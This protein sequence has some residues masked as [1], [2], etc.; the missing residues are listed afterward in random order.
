VTIQP[1]AAEDPGAGLWLSARIAVLRGLDRIFRTEVRNQLSHEEQTQHE[2][3]KAS[4]TMGRYLAESDSRDI[5]VLDF[6]CGWGGETIWLA[7]YVRTVVGFDVDPGSIAQAQ[8][9]VAANGMKNCRF[10]SSADGRLPLPDDSV[11]AVFSTDTFEHVM[12]LGLAYSEIFRVLRAGG[13]LRTAFGPLFYSPYGY[14]LH[15]ACQVPYA[16]L[17]FGLAPILELRREH[18]GTRAAAERWEDTGL[19]RKRFA[20]FRNAT[21]AAGF[22]IERF[23]AVPVR[24]LTLATRIPVLRDLLTFGVDCVARKPN[25]T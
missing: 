10:V 20:D 24:G 25:S 22:Q 7:Q 12:D 2:M 11:D 9:A 17:L 13:V 21:R 8:L 14:H 3:Q 18:S 23:T 15:W 16:H 4:G 6:G 19:N 5:D 1:Q